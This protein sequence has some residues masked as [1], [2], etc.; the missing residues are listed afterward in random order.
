MSVTVIVKEKLPVTVGVPLSTP[1]LELSARPLGNDP[2]LTLKVTV[3]APPDW[4]SCW[5]Y[6]VPIMPA[7]RAGGLI[8]IVGQPLAC[9]TVKV[10]PAMV[11]VPV[12]RSPLLAATEKLTVPLPDPLPPLLIVIQLGLLLV[13]VQA[14][15]VPAVTFTLPLP[16]LEPND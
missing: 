14:Q 12:R 15:P 6:V 9:V 7:G 5:L 13:A 11:I 2:A 10:F 1:V 8:E 16:P 4:V 3:P